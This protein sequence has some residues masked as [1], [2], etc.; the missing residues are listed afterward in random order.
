L[1]QSSAA[2]TAYA[3]DIIAAPFGCDWGN[4]SVRI[5]TFGRLGFISLGCDLKGIP[6]ID[7]FRENLYN[8]VVPMLNQTR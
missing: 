5:A 3:I 6:N 2:S 8:I 7:V 1:H 4:R